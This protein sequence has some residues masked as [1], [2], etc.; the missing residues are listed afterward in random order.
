MTLTNVIVNKKK[1]KKSR[2]MRKTR[3]YVLSIYYQQELFFGYIDK[4]W[5]KNKKN[6]GNCIYYLSYS[7]RL[8]LFLFDFVPL[9]CSCRRALFEKLQCCTEKTFNVRLCSIIC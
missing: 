5:I 3:Q 2:L 4:E 7:E 6:L 9:C 1:K 8:N